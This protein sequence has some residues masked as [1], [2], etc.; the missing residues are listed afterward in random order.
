[1]F[2]DTP[3]AAKTKQVLLLFWLQ[4]SLSE[5]PQILW[6]KWRKSAIFNGEYKYKDKRFPSRLLHNSHILKILLYSTNSHNSLHLSSSFGEISNGRRVDKKA[7]V[8][9][10]WIFHNERRR[11]TLSCTDVNIRKKI[12]WDIGSSIMRAEI[13]VLWYGYEYT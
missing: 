10:D 9:R 5:T 3:A 12:D 4:T 1:M 8:D 6:K 11:F 7:Q 13:N 2:W